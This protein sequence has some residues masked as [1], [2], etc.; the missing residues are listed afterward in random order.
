MVDHVKLANTLWEDRQRL[1]S[2][3]SI[4]LK[5]KLFMEFGVH[6]GGSLRQFKKLYDMFVPNASQNLMYGFDSFEGLPE[7][8]KDK[9]N[10]DYWSVG[11]FD[12]SGVIPAD[13]NENNGYK[14]V[15]GWFENTLT[16]EFAE[17]IK[18]KKIGLLH[19]DCDIYSSTYTVLDFCFSNN[20]I[21]PGTI[22]VYD[23]WGVY[24]DTPNVKTEFDMGEGLAHAEILKK[25]GR[26][27]T[28]NKRN[29]MTSPP[30]HHQHYEITVFTVD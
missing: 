25:Y 29:L 7:E 12:L 17:S 11:E 22:L 24:R 26:T 16:S 30:E 2:Q 18:G 10:P 1:I 6:A 21:V 28:L 15:K 19:I 13:L 14:M 23:D 20:L 27:A 5:D 4:F 3:N 9:N 8:T